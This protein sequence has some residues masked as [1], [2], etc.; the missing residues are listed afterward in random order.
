M[1]L[2]LT[3]PLF[4]PGLVRLSSEVNPDAYVTISI[5]RRAV[6]NDSG[7]LFL[8]KHNAYQVLI[9]NNSMLQ[10]PGVPEVLLPGDHTFSSDT[11]EGLKTILPDGDW[12]SLTKEKVTRKFRLSSVKLPDFVTIEDPMNLKSVDPKLPLSLKLGSLEEGSTFSLTAI[13]SEDPSYFK[14]DFVKSRLAGFEKSYKVAN[15]LYVNDYNINSS[16]MSLELEAPAPVA[17]PL[18]LSDLKLPYQTGYV[19]ETDSKAEFHLTSLDVSV[20]SICST[21]LKTSFDPTLVEQ[22]YTHW[23]EN[24]HYYKAFFVPAGIS[25]TNAESAAEAEGG[26]L[27]TITSS[28]ENDFV[29]GLVKDR[30]YWAIVGLIWSGPWLGGTAPASRKQP[31]VGWTWVT[32]ETWK[33]ANW[34]AGEPNNNGGIETHSSFASP[35]HRTASTWNDT[36]DEALDTAGYATHAS[37]IVEIDGYHPKTKVDLIEVPAPTDYVAG[38]RIIHQVGAKSRV[39]QATARFAY[40]PVLF[41]GNDNARNWVPFRGWSP[42]KIPYEDCPLFS[43]GSYLAGGIPFVAPKKNP[44]WNGGATST[45]DWTHASNLSQLWDASLTGDQV[46]NIPTDVKGVEEVYTLINLWAGKSHADPP[47]AFI[48]FEGDKGAFVRFPIISG[49]QAR[50]IW[51]SPETA[52]DREIDSRA[53]SAVWRGAFNYVL[54]KQ[55][56]KLPLAFESQTLVAI[57][58]VDKGGRYIQRLILSGITAKVKTE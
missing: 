53:V 17:G 49:V 45:L 51:N 23:V 38:G 25:W 22:G 20:D 8:A 56:W 32:G 18:K 47:L 46:L 21:P 16:G 50:D 58:L 35:S 52:Q 29:Y 26:H 7:K 3:Y 40:I 27:A 39:Y 48:E 44:V 28:S 10:L 41:D 13:D 55:V 57:R 5:K 19:A 33:Y 30:L 11:E 4:L 43:G 36:P 54:D 34:L 1:F 6:E 24:D 31:I 14:G 15:G 2:V 37:Y 12:V 9:R 42:F